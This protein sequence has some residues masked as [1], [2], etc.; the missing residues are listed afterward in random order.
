MAFTA[1]SVVLEVLRVMED[2]DM[3]LNDI[4]VGLVGGRLTIRQTLY[5]LS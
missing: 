3:V 2:I 4:S 5:S 1:L